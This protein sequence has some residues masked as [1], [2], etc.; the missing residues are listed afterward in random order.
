MKSRINFFDLGMFDGGETAM[1][2][3]DIKGLDVEP[4]VYGFE[5]YPPFYD[6]I[7][8]RFKDKQNIHVYNL[9]ISNEESTIKLFLEK[10]GQ[11]NSIFKTK[12]NVNPNKFVEVK[13]VSFVD[14][15]NENVRDYQNDINILRFNIEGAELLLINDIV[16]KDVVN[17]FNVYLGSHTGVDIK[18]VASIKDKFNGYVKTLKDNDIII[19]LYCQDLKGKNINLTE[20]IK[21]LL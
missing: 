8:E 4:H 9:A 10:S 18:K 20:I 12:N 17:N 16:N 15:V 11:G 1:F 19:Q 13:S 7:V 5:A 2:L 21:G 14:W 6:K 3:E